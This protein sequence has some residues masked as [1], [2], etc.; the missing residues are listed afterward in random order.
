MINNL[1]LEENIRVIFDFMIIFSCGL[2]FI[3]G[4]AIGQGYYLSGNRRC[5]GNIQLNPDSQHAA[6]TEDVALSFTLSGGI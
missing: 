3:S 4:L 1:L 5:R 6:V 2:L